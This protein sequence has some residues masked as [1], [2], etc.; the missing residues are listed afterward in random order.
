MPLFRAEVQRVRDQVQ[1]TAGARRSLRK[2]PRAGRRPAFSQQCACLDQRQADQ[3]GSGRS[4]RSR[5]AVRCPA[6]LPSH[7]RRSRT[8]LLCAGSARSRRRRA[9][10]NR[11]VTGTSAMP[12]NPFAAQ[13]TATA[14]WNTT[15]WPRMPPQLR[16][17]RVRELPGFARSPRRQDRPPGPKPITTAFGW[18][19]AT[20]GVLLQARSRCASRGGASPA[21]RSLVDLRRHHVEWQ[22]QALQQFRAD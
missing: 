4:T 9:G 8:V 14:V 12:A 3:R 5:R 6:S 21:S 2:A 10:E 19:C 17:R 16:E 18:R 13:T 15:A 7:C 1:R 22:A 11:T 20:R